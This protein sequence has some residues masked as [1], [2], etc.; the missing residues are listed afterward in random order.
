[1]ADALAAAVGGGAAAF[2]LTN[3]VSLLHFCCSRL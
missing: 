2:L 1:L 3:Q